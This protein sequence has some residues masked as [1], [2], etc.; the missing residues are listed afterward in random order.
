M[1]ELLVSGEI[2]FEQPAYLSPRAIAYVRLLDTSLADAPMRLIAEQVLRNIASQA[3]AGQPL[4][5]VLYGS[6]PNMRTH[7]SISVLIDLNEDGR[8]SQGDWITT[9]SYPVL[10]FGYPN[11]ITVHVK[12]VK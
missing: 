5:F 2:V 7:Y 9:Q 3:N 12:L 4:P 6:P 1:I 11:H 10:T 8:I